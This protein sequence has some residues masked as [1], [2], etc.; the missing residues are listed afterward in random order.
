MG[1]LG[2]VEMMTTMTRRWAWEFLMTGIVAAIYWAICLTLLTKFSQPP[3][4]VDVIPLFIL[5]S[6]FA[7]RETEV[8]GG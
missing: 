1:V 5:V 3:H 7:S 4:P 6:I 8:Q 2:V